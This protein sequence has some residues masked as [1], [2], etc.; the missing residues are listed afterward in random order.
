MTPRPGRRR[1]LARGLVLSL[2]VLAFAWESEGG[3]WPSLDVRTSDGNTVNVS[4]ALP[5]R[6]RTGEAHFGSGWVWLT[7]SGTRLRVS[8]S[9][10]ADGPLPHGE[11]ALLCADLWEHAYYVDYRNARPK[12]VEEFWKRVNWD[13]ANKNLA[14]GY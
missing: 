11:L 9:S 5:Y 2:Q 14:A 6:V 10:D 8:S 3:R 1:R 4:I 13:F 12:Y 7:W